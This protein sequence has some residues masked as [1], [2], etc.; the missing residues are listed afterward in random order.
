LITSAASLTAIAIT[1]KRSQQVLRDL[2]RAKDEFVSI[3][4]HEL[5]TPLAAIMGYAEML[6]TGEVDADC[7][8]DYLTEIHARGEALE[9]LIDEL[10]DVSLIQ[11]GRGLAM[12]RQPTVLLAM[13]ERVVGP[14]RRSAPLHQIELRCSPDL[15][16]TIF[17]DAVRITQVL[18]NLLGNAIK[19]S[20]QGGTVTLGIER[21]GSAVRFCVSDQGVGM[22]EDALRHAFDK[23]YREDASNTAPGGLGLGLCIVREIINGHNGVID[24]KS[25]PSEGTQ[26]TFSLPI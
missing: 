12:E 3:A 21:N 24:V 10:L 18:E 11:V 9:R 5:R 22:S 4:A 20:P 8:R 26:V 2:D 15:P 25:R 19:Y 16:A 14:C 7:Q 17:C 1:Y 23:F 6:V 13:V